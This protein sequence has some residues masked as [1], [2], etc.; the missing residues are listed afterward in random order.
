MEFT[1][2]SLPSLLLGLAPLLAS[3]VAGVAGAPVSQPKQQGLL[4]VSQPLLNA[5]QPGQRGVLN[6]PYDDFKLNE[7]WLYSDYSSSEGVRG[8]RGLA[9]PDPGCLAARNSRIWLIADDI[10]GN[11]RR[12][13]RYWEPGYGPVPPHA[14]E[15]HTD[16]MQFTLYGNRGP[17]DILDTWDK[18]NGV[19]KEDNSGLYECG[20]ISG[21]SLFHCVG[22]SPPYNLQGMN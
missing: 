9:G 4:D 2:S 3:G 20:D 5:T 8:I 16:K 13:S 10:S 21:R 15:V 1:V 11:K 12:G 6:D 14:L 22:W 17:W 19:C 18:Q 7:F